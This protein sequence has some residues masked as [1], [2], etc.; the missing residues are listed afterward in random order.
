[1]I[2]FLPLIFLPQDI[3]GM[4]DKYDTGGNVHIRI[5]LYCYDFILD[6]ANIQMHN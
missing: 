6:T 3:G 2:A 1:M 4:E 5:L